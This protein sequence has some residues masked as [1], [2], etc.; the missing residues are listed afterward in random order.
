MKRVRQWSGGLIVGAAFLAGTQVLL[1]SPGAQVEKRDLSKYDN[2]GHY[3]L[4]YTHKA[5]LPRGQAKAREFL[6]SHWKGQRRGWVTL[7]YF[8]PDAQTKQSFFVEP[9]SKAVWCVRITMFELDFTPP[10]PGEKGPIKPRV[11]GYA[12]AYRVQRVERNYNPDGS[13]TPVPENAK[14]SGE[15]YT[16]LF[17]GKTGKDIFGL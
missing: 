5:D 6:W 7:D 11:Q 2:G 8:S 14:R 15:S 3:E 13:Q 1:S 9:D 16:L 12:P 17:E 4:S 10:G